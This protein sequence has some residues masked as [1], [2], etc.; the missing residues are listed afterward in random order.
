M[1]LVLYLV[2]ITALSPLLAQDWPEQR[3]RASYHAGVAL[4]EP[5]LLV[6]DEAAIA[7]EWG[8][9]APD[10]SLPINGFSARYRGVF[11]FSTATW[12]FETRA[13]DGLRL[14]VDGR[15]VLDAWQGSTGATQRVLVALAEGMHRV[16]LAYHEDS[17][18]AQLALNWSIY[19]G[20]PA[21]TPPTQAWCA[22]YFEDRAFGGE[23]S[24]ANHALGTVQLVSEAPGDFGNDGFSVRIHGRFQFA[25]G[26]TRFRLQARD[27]VRLWLDGRLLYQ[28]WRTQAKA[29]HL[30]TTYV[31]AGEHLVRVEGF[32]TW[33]HD[34]PTLEWALDQGQTRL[35]ASSPL[36]TN[37]AALDY[38]STEWNLLDAMKTAG[39][40]YT[41]TAQVWDTREQD[42]LDLDEHG[43]VRSLP[44][45]DDATTTFRSV[46]AVALNGTSGTYRPGRYLLLYQ[47]KGTLEY[48]FDARRNAAL[49]RPGRDVLDVDNAGNGG[50]L[51]RILATDP[52]DYLR[53]FH[54]I[55]DAALCDDQPWQL[56]QSG[57]GESCQPVEALFTTRP[58][59][60][61]FLRD[62]RGFRVLR[63]MDL[64]HTNDSKLRSWSD[65]PRMTDA[66]WSGPFGAPL[67]L[68]LTLANQTGVDPWLN[69]PTQVDDDFVVHMA[70][71]V[72]AQLAPDRRVY[73]EYSNEIWNTAFANGDWVEAQGLASWPAASFSAYTKRINWYGKR[74]AEIVGLFKDVFGAESHR[75][76]GVMGGFAAGAWASEQALACPLATAE[77]SQPCWSEMDALAI[78]PYFGAYLGQPRFADHLAEWLNQ[79]DGG[80]GA[81]FTELR[82]GGLLYDANDPEGERAPQDGA[83]ARA[84][85]YTRD[86]V[87][88]AARFGLQL[89]A[90]EGG[91]HLAGV[92]AQQDNAAL[93]ALFVAANR[94]PRMAALYDDYLRH[95]REAGGQLM[96]HFLS[97]G[98]YGRYGS[99]GAKEHQQQ[100]DAPKFKALMRFIENYP[101][102]WPGCSQPNAFPSYLVVPF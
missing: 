102:W 48:G 79:T 96:C 93:T 99:W 14:W 70:Q 49:S 42:K 1:R 46:A 45:A 13:D 9:S 100:Q 67:E 50:I 98:A 58:F 27:G 2:L 38:W 84:Y 91:Q 34:G 29:E 12:Q 81:L 8:F 95:W 19:Q 41:Q 86:G 35:G 36:G 97:V 56:C 17:G 59:Q 89:I 40:W 60:P 33:G 22:E 7:H 26:F 23:I 87:D 37:I 73:V 25:E 69:V 94:D 83:L 82:D 5:A 3:F 16:E 72:L 68:A 28:D 61:E 53:D 80:L 31:P 65:R 76:V 39:G 90:Y 11:F 71:T 64:F 62:L 75:V 4:A 15:L 52:D 101:C 24:P 43:W 6:R 44:A 77:G 63:F 54:L 20:L 66:R 55:P 30:V 57:C 78:A 32:R 21:C 47:G 88:I 85:E 74:S 18:A 51:I 10:P 92:A